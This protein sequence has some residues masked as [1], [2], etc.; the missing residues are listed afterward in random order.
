ML[1]ALAFTYVAPE[2][3]AMFLCTLFI[4]F[5]FSSL[6]STPRQTMVIWTATTIGLAGLFLLTDKPI[7]TYRLDGL[8]KAALIEKGWT[9][10]NG[11]A[12]IRSHLRFERCLGE[13][14]FAVPAEPAADDV[15]HAAIGSEDEDAVV[16]GIGNEDPAVRGPRTTA[17][18]ASATARVR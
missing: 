16:A 15:L 12:L 18:T 11:L 2:V 4:V 1:I 13:G 6:R 17:L 3:G 14:T 5:S 10:K 8:H 7:V 9:E